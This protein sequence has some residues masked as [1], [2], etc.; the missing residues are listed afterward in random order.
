MFRFIDCLGINRQ[1]CFFTNAIMGMRNDDNSLGRSPAWKDID[2]MEQ[3]YTFFKTQMSEIKPKVV[4]ILGKQVAHFVWKVYKSN[5]DNIGDWERIKDVK[6]LFES[7]NFHK[8]IGNVKFIYMTHP[9]LRPSNISQ[10]WGPKDD[11]KEWKNDVELGL[12]HKLIYGT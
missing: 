6:V 4:F 10:T 2:F 5:S 9:S 8:T 12:T 3:C 7:G 11:K 1:E